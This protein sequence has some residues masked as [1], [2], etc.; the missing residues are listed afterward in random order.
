M[1]GFLHFVLQSCI[2]IC[3]KK[4]IYL[5][6]ARSKYLKDNVLS[7]PILFSIFI[8]SIVLAEYKLN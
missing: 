5:F 1:D 3:I 6:A 4:S 7:F 2:G 8:Y